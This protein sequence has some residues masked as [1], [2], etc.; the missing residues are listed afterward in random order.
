MQFESDPGFFSRFQR[1]AQIG[2]TLNHP[3]ILL[4][5]ESPA[6]SEPALLSSAEMLEGQTLGH[7]MG[8]RP[9]HAGHCRCLRITSLICEAL[10]YMHE[11]EVVHPAIQFGRTS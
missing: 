4:P 9:A 3:Y 7:L 10:H 11:H 5:E 8:K 1:E 2:K 6:E